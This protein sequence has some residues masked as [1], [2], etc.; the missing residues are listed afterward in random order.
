MGKQHQPIHNSIRFDDLA[1]PVFAGSTVDDPSAQRLAA[2]AQVPRIIEVLVWPWPEAGDQRVEW[3]R[4]YALNMAQ[5]IARANEILVRLR[6]QELS[7]VVTD[8]RPATRD[9]NEAFFRAMDVLESQ[10]PAALLASKYAVKDNGPALR[11][12]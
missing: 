12:T 11:R 5:A 7:M 3:R 9:E 1:G 4:Y 6:E 8:I 2:G 10:M